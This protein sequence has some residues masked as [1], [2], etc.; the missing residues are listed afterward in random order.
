MWP[1]LAI[2]TS[3][4]LRF[5][6]FPPLP[7][8]FAEDSPIYPLGRVVSYRIQKK[9][10]AA[11]NIIQLTGHV[12]FDRHCCHRPLV[13]SWHHASRCC[14]S[15]LACCCCNIVCGVLFVLLLLCGCRRC[16]KIFAVGCFFFFLSLLRCFCYCL[17][18]ILVAHQHDT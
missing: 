18:C 1:V 8:G 7:K 14:Y 9:K 13:V 10:T 16:G 3:A 15:V 17:L 6:H 5:Q 12:P 4:V 11:Q 2:K